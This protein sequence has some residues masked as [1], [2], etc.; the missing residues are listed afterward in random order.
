MT[1]AE[2]CIEAQ[3]MLS[4]VEMASTEEIESATPLEIQWRKGWEV[5]R[6]LRHKGAGNATREDLNLI[7]NKTNIVVTATDYQAAR[8]KESAADRQNMTK[9]F[10]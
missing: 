9:Y 8:A 1:Y 5:R 7:E 2:F 10:G 6:A 3:R 4:P